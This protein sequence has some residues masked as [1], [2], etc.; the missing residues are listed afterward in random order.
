M[1]LSEVFGIA[2]AVGLV[3]GL[4]QWL[5]CLLWSPKKKICSED[6]FCPVCGY[7]CRGRGGAGCIDKPAMLEALGND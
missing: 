2:G 3:A 1:P 7:Y 4:A 5:R 6:L